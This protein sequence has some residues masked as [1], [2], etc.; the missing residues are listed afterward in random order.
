MEE[1]I[2]SAQAMSKMMLMKLNRFTKTGYIQCKD[3]KRRVAAKLITE[4]K[5]CF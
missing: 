2:N 4:N 1:A 3:A 5:Y